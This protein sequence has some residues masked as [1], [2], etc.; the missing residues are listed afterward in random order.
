MDINYIFAYLCVCFG[1]FAIYYGYK[2][3]TKRQKEKIELNHILLILLFSLIQIYI[4]LSEFN[5]YK[6]FINLF[7]NVVFITT[8]YRDNFKNIFITVLLLYSVEIL[9][10]LVYSF[11]FLIVN[12]NSYII[13]SIN[14]LVIRNLFSILVVLNLIL[15]LSIKSTKKFLNK[16]LYLIIDKQAVIVRI[17]L[18]I[19]YLFIIYI[20]IIYTININIKNYYN[21]LVSSI[22]ILSCMTILIKYK[23]KIIDVEENQK[24]ILEYMKKYEFLIDKYRINKHEML[25]NLV[26]LNSYEDKNSIEFKKLLKELINNY[27][28]SYKT[29]YRNIGYLP[30]GIKGILYYKINIIEKNNINFTFNCIKN[31]NNLLNERNTKDYSKLCRLLNIF[32]DNAIEAANKSDQKMIILDIY[33]ENNFI[34]FYIE[35]SFSNKLNINLINEK[36]YSTKGKNR[37]IGLFIAQKLKRSS[38]TIEYEQYINKSKNFVTKLKIRNN[39]T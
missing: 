38:T 11:I 9:F 33:M 15:T 39:H 6:I 21:N 24:I 31:L 10:E 2:I 13:T 5:E 4:G 27:S 3:L 20:I 36:Y 1:V 34:V 23:N 22:I 14:S 8:I 7:L 26:L 17:L 29:E 37:G 25:N 35:N 19:F 12:S 32:L 18:I 28:T 16:I 30:A